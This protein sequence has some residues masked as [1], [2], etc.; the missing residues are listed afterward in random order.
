MVAS[1]LNSLS[2]YNKYGDRMLKYPVDVESLAHLMMFNINVN[3]HSKDVGSKYTVDSNSSTRHQYIT[4]KN[5]GLQAS[6]Y[7][8]GKGFEANLGSVKLQTGRRTVRT[9]NSI[10]LYVP[11]TLVFD[12]NQ[13]YENMS[14]TKEFG[15]GKALAASFGFNKGGEGGALAGLGLAAAGSMAAKSVGAGINRRASGPGISKALGGSISK[16]GEMAGK[17]LVNAGKLSGFAVNPMIEIIYVQ[18]DLRQFQ[19]DFNFSPRSAKEA[20]A[21]KNIIKEFRRNQAPEFNST[22]GLAGAVFLP[23]SNF[24]I[25]FHANINGNFVQNLNIPKISTCVLKTVNTNYAP[26]MFATFSDGKPVTIQM[27]LVFQELD[28]ITRERIDEGY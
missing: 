7:V 3:E 19:F 14:L 17:G 27:R 16:I 9:T 23:P 11:D 12:D 10:V 26:Q 4:D 1:P 13:Q 24:D 22:T 18:P 15:T 8:Q 20:E 5:G 21:V 28:M 25:S 6:E 2:D